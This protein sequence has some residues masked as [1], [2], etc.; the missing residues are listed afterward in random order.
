[1]L[2]KD[3]TNDIIDILL[4]EENKEPIVLRDG[5]GR[6]LAFEQIAVIPYDQKIYCVLKPIDHIDSIADDE[7]IVFYVDEGKCE[8]DEPTLRVEIDELKALE[9]FE[10]YYNLLEE[11]I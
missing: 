3:R 11:E 5:N 6:K 4:D 9:V 10:Q 7:A 2:N 1:M 8:D